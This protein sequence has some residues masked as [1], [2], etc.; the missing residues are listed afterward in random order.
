MQLRTKDHS[1]KH[2]DFI[3]LIYLIKN[4]AKRYIFYV[5]HPSNYI[6]KY[7]KHFFYLFLYTYTYFK[8]KIFER[9]I[10][11]ILLQ[12]SKENR[13]LNILFQ[14][15]QITFFHMENIYK[16]QHLHFFLRPVFWS[17]FRNFWNHFLKFHLSVLTIEQI[18]YLSIFKAIIWHLYIFGTIVFQSLEFLSVTCKQTMIIN[19]I[20]HRSPVTAN[21]A[22]IMLHKYKI[23][24]I[25]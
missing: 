10:S 4:I 21:T 23:D 7:N 16:T 3:S 5:Y 8:R 9:F 12:A 18:I 25:P 20:H 17:F 6:K 15:T 22:L 24:I 1:K 13:Y 14:N 2:D 19:A 11:N